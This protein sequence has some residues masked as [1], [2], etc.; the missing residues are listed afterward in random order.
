MNH[1]DFSLEIKDLPAPA[2]PVLC[3]LGNDR[4]IEALGSTG[5]SDCQA[6]AQGTPV[7]PFVG[8][9]LD[10]LF[11]NSPYLTQCALSNPKFILEIINHGPEWACGNIKDRLTHLGNNR[12]ADEALMMRELRQAKRDLSLAV[13]VADIANIWSVEQI[14]CA[15]SDFADKTLS[16]AASYTLRKA[17]ASGAIT[18]AH[19]DDPERDSGY[20]IL[21]MGKLGAGELNY[22]SDID[23]I[24]LFD[25]EVIQSDK[26]GDLQRQFVRI[27]RNLVKVMD[28][29]TA[30]GYVFRTDLRLRPDPGATPITV[31][32]QAAEVYYESLGQNWERAA[33]IKARPVAGD[34]QAGNAFIDWLT[35]F[36]WRKHLDF[37]AI[38]DIHS[39]KR[40]INAHRGGST[41]ALAGHNIKLGRGG[42]REIE[43][44][45]QTQQL[46]WGG[47]SSELRKIKTVDALETLAEKER[48]DPSVATE[49]TTSYRFLRR[50]EHRLQMVDDAQTHTLPSDDNGLNKIAIFL[51]YENAETFGEALLSHLRTV[52]THYAALFEG[53]APLSIEGEV[54]GNLVFTGA[55]TDPETL[56]T[57]ESMGFENPQAVDSMVRGWHHGRYRSTHNTRARQ[58]LTELMPVLLTELGD[59]ANPDQAFLRFNKFLARLPAGIQLFSMFHSNPHLLT[60][61]AEIMGEAPKLAQHLSHKPS[62]L[63]SVLDPKFFDA[64]PS[65]DELHRDLEAILQQTEYVEEMLDATRR[66]ANDRWFQI[67]VQSLRGH[68]QPK[69]TAIALSYIAE[70]SVVLLNSAMAKEFELRHGVVPGSEMVVLAL[71]KLGGRE[72]TSTSDLDMIF[73]YK[74]PAE[75]KNSNGPKPLALTQYFA[76]LSQRVINSITAQTSEGRLFEVDMRLRPSGNAGP[77]ASSLQAFVQYHDELSWTWEHMAMTRAR[78]VA[79]PPNLRQEVEGV[80]TEVLT[81]PRDS[82]KLLTDVAEMRSRIDNEH[83]TE[84]PLA[85]KHLRGGLVD[86][87]FISQYLQLKHAHEHQ[88]ILSPNTHKAIG[89][90][91]E[92]GFLNNKNG[93]TLISALELW[94]GIQGL[95]RLTMEEHIPKDLDHEIPKGLQEGLATLGQV[96]NFKSLLEKISITAGAV[97]RI[98]KAL[99][100]TPAGQIKAK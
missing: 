69:T 48:I 63:D 90:L 77:I 99:I 17:A 46:I 65:P 73:V 94:Q 8:P 31:S 59:T 2:D 21:G 19:E 86:I 45:T 67:G 95:F 14:T 20:I 44:F 25:P 28:E 50:V 16:C 98:F 57:L 6:V 35:S 74:A 85:V 68:Q 18:L 43:F 47:R 29:R 4:W 26:P 32:V 30:D 79:G 3:A 24:I 7:N 33:M 11:G 80:I 42:I 81:Q 49:M 41:I 64:P 70:C 75:A 12:G 66:W 100:E 39:I 88:E 71:G 9:L 27:T 96:D 15:L 23:L 84:N 92:Y 51:G 83:H 93:E 60:L 5:D 10:S 55:D 61:V 40:Q 72:M 1:L 13:A 36:V 22:S 76:R 78:V 38:R 37:E 34:I 58:L 53:S 52:E 97:Q 82:S 91:M 54:R 87:E 62:V 89:N 56:R